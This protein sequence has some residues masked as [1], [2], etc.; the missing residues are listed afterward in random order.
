MLFISAC[1]SL[2]P[3]AEAPAIGPYHNIT[4]RLLVIEP[5]RR[6]QV[7]LDW[8]AQKTSGQARLVHAASGNIVELRWQKD[9]IRLRDNHAPN[10]R[11]IN[12]QQLAEHGIVISPYSLSRF[13]A[14][15][16]PAGF[17]RKNANTWESKRGG[18]LIRVTWRNANKRLIISDIRH[19][20]RA[21]LIIGKTNHSSPD[22][23][24]D[25]DD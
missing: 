22:A 9:D 4:A 24:G 18:K 16:I 25:V 23:A 3:S 2:P 13:L 15:Q 19:G 6:W 12:M 20:R 17:R 7:M 10:W 14:G 1:A 5:K 21:T 8:Q 11:K